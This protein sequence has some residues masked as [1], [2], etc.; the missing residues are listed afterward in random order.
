M[1]PKV[2][3]SPRED[4]ADITID[5]Y[6]I[7]INIKPIE[8]LPQEPEPPTQPTQLT[9]AAEAPNEAPPGPPEAQTHPHATIEGLKLD[10]DPYID[11]LTITEE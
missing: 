10:L 7:E 8:T 1:A 3:V 11:D 6:I 9:I 5:G 4:G 2:K